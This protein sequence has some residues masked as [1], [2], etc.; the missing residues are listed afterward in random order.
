MLETLL[1]E[2][3]PNTAAFLEKVSPSQAFFL[4]ILLSFSE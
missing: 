1:V 3:K 4:V 2:L